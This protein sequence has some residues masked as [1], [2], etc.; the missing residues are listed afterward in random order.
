[1][2]CRL[3]LLEELFYSDKS[4]RE[5][6][7]ETLFLKISSFCPTAVGHLYPEKNQSHGV[8]EL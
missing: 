6:S 2:R 3:F 8:R 7:F 5:V 4:C 1:M